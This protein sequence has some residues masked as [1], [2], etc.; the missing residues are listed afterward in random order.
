[1]KLLSLIVFSS[2]EC[3]RGSEQLIRVENGV[4]VLAAGV[5]TKKFREDTALI[6]RPHPDAVADRRDPPGCGLLQ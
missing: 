3:Q 1:V 6:V 2:L 5:R 4:T